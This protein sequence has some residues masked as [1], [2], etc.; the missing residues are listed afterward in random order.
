M[1]WFCFLFLVSFT[2]FGAFILVL[3]LNTAILLC[4]VVIL[5]TLIYVS[6]CFSSLFSCSVFTVLLQ[7]FA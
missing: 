4:F 2:N 5:S 1:P 3:S 6:H 7:W